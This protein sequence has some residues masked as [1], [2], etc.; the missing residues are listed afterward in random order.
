[1]NQEKFKN[2]IILKD[3][4]SNLIEEAI[5]ILKDNNA[6]DKKKKEEYSREEATNIIKEYISRENVAN[7]KGRKKI[8]LFAFFMIVIFILNFIRVHIY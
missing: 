5:I 1:M 8:Y 4:P 2:I 6:K 3:I 7:K